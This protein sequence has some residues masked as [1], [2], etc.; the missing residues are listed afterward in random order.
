M[1]F[2]DSI[3]VIIKRLFGV[4]P[5]TTDAE[6]SQLDL[7][8][9]Q[10]E[11]TQGVNLTAIFAGKLSALTVTDS[12]V[13][14]TGE[15][16]RAEML[17]S[18]IQNI[19]G[20]VRNWTGIAFGSGGVVLIPYV[21]AGKIF[22]DIIPQS[23]MVINQVNGD[24]LQAVS[25]LADSTVQNDQRYFRWT[26][27]ILDENGILTIRQRATGETGSPV[28]I[29]NI[30]EWATVAEEMSITGVEHLPLA[31]IK[32]PAGNRRGDSMY[33]VPITY[34]CED[35][36]KEID[37]CLEDVRREYRLKKPIVGMD[38]TMFDVRNGKRNLPVTGLFMPIMAGGLDG[39]KKL[40][41][42][43]D[44]AI[45]DSAYYNRL[46]NLYELLEKQVGTSRGILTESQS[47]GATATEIKAGMYDTYSI[48]QLMRTAI[49]QGLDRLAYA[50]DVLANLYGL[51]PMGD[52]EVTF[53]WS[54]SLIESSQESFTQ[55]ISAAQVGAVEPAE[56][57]QYVF[58][59]ETLEEAQ[60][61][62]AEIASA[63]ADSTS[64][65]LDQALAREAAIG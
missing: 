18:A 22:T 13:E 19:W 7:Q 48:I 20:K 37:E 25:V 61:R 41:E 24:E 32:C 62:C 14:V 15:N 9:R 21:A 45:R 50:M 36:M 49:E 3:R 5:V 53:D 40:W 52:H 65:L 54:Y 33:G 8:N 29:T 30:T 44:P 60:A 26:D 47:R 11:S 63:K 39:A 58:N 38:Q 46:T 12:T 35:L 57:R 59:D 43:Y 10:Y 17:N 51:S 42:V 1:N 56:I 28:P 6:T 64:L 34:G 4:D 16:Q 55:L 27:Y 2:A 23:R 31:Y